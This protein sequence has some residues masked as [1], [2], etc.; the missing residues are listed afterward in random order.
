VAKG[1]RILLRVASF[2]HLIG[3]GKKRQLIAILLTGGE[4]HDGT[5]AERLIRRVNHRNA[6]SATKPSA[7]LRDQLHDLSTTGWLE[8]FGLCLSGRSPGMVD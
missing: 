1:E 8:L 7:E 4:T 2:D 3:A 6:C 5:I